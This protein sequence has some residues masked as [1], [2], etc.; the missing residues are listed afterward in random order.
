MGLTQ[1]Q[2]LPSQNKESSPWSSRSLF[3]LTAVSNTLTKNFT[4]PF[5]ILLTYMILIIGIVE[6][7]GQH[8]SWVFLILTI[9]MLV[10]SFL[11]RRRE[12]VVTKKKPKTKV[13][14]K[15]K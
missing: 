12:P 15:I 10:V 14:E 4:N 9:A 8:V 13:K 1:D 6:I 3:S 7:I 5:E 2:N 11:E